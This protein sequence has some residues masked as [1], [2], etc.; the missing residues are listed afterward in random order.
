MSYYE[1]TLKN[2]LIPLLYEASNMDKLK[3]ELNYVEKLFMGFEKPNNVLSKV[4]LP[5]YVTSRFFHASIGPKYGT[6]ME[7][8]ILSVV[9][10]K[11]GYQ[12]KSRENIY[13][14]LNIKY[15][16]KKV[17]DFIFYRNDK[18][19]FVEQ[20]LSSHTGGATAQESL[21]DKFREILDLN[22]LNSSILSK[23]KEI[24][25]RIFILFNEK[26]EVANRDNIERG[27]INSLIKYILQPHWLGEKFDLLKSKFKTNC[28]NFETCLK[29]G[30][31][32]EFADNYRK[33][34]F[35]ILLGDEFFKELL[36]T[37]SNVLM[38]LLTESGDD[39]WIL[40]TLLPF[41]LRNY[42]FNGYTW[43]RRIYDDIIKNC[44]ISQ[45]GKNEDEI[46]DSLIIK[47][48]N[49]Y[50]S[51]NLLE[52]TDLKKQIEYLRNVI[53]A[54]LVIKAVGPSTELILR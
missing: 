28:T 8:I 45:L 27:R 20:R 38:D 10:E 17:I 52:T 33:I 37:S 54:G 12:G 22:I 48:L 47:V 7:D 49:K 24:N 40:Y 3:N 18:I 44:D 39:L 23:F 6:L 43:T 26:H 31:I 30:K 34:T 4:A 16:D 5:L 25:L 35:G 36:S 21:L 51:L 29:E 9:K 1:S 32:I 41:E 53:A 15:K 19:Y 11:G 50:N 14:F 2:F 42:V 13:D 46:I